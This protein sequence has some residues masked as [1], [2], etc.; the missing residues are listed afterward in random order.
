[1]LSSSLDNEQQSRLSNSNLLHR[2]R[3][4]ILEFTIDN[5]T[6]KVR[7]CFR[8]IH[9]DLM[10]KWLY[11]STKYIEISCKL[12][13]LLLQV[14]QIIKTGQTK[15]NQCFVL[16][17]EFY[18]DKEYTPSTVCTYLSRKKLGK[19]QSRRQN[20]SNTRVTYVY[21]AIFEESELH[22]IQN[23]NDAHRQVAQ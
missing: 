8:R 2:L 7:A 5:P 23:G 16:H 3:Q 11:Q 10:I 19:S 6:E 22:A 18:T 21:Q 1:M 17:P 15:G 20:G 13:L 14:H 9:G 4:D 12:I